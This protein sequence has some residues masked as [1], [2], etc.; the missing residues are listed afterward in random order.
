[1][2]DFGLQMRERYQFDLLEISP[3]G[4]LGIQYLEADDPPSIDDVAEAVTGVMHSVA[5]K[6]NVQLPKLVLEPGRSMVGQAGMTLYTA[7][8][9]KDIPNVRKYVSVDGGI[10]DNV[11]PALYQARYE[12]IVAN[13]AEKP[14]AETVTIAGKYCESGDILISDIQL[15]AIE[16]GDIIA[17]PATGAYCIPMASNY[18][19]SLKPPIVVVNDGQ[20]TMVRRRETY[21][22]LFSCEV[23]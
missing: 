11:R 19:L 15:P 6:R 14:P 18:N 4:G 8:S 13:K 16:P 7:G 1:L 21:D 2:V 20:A 10:A 3:G 12:A 23:A 17:L 22:D 5:T 9:I